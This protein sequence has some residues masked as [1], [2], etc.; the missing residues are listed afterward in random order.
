MIMQFFVGVKMISVNNSVPEDR[1]L[2]QTAEKL[3]GLL[4]TIGEAFAYVL[5]GMYGQIGDIGYF[6]AGLL[7][8]QLIMAVVIVILL[9]EMLENGYGLGSGISLFIATNICEN[10]IWKALSPIT[11]KSGSGT[12]FEGALIAL[13]HLLATKSN[14]MDALYQA[15]YRHDAPNISNLMGTVIIILVVIYLQGFKMHLTL[16]HRKIRGYYQDYPIK[17]FYTSTFP[18]ILQAAFISNIYFF[19]QILHRKFKGNFFIDLLGK[20]KDVDFGARSVPVG[21]LAYYM[22]P[23]KDF[24]HFIADPIHGLFYTTFIMAS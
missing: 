18:I 10:I 16:A 9:D 3:F 2:Y 17:L 22:S 13:F 14:K 5:S 11:I 12:Q 4:M 1:K 7:I 21:G 24:S 15:F 8:L 19:S 20:W 6:N 23:P